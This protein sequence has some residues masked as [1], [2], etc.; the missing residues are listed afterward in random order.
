MTIITI[1]YRTFNYQIA[2]CDPITI[3]NS[4]NGPALPLIVSWDPGDRTHMRSSGATISNRD[5]RAPII[6]GIFLKSCL[7]KNRANLSS[8]PIYGDYSLAP[9]FHTRVSHTRLNL[10]RIFCLKVW[11]TFLSK[12]I[13]FYIKL[14]FL[15]LIK[16]YWYIYIYIYIW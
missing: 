11:A 10:W 6:G 15:F 7:I 16:N 4:Q 13:G 3:K 1:N 12:Y 9:C 14:T 8:I 2:S 5:R